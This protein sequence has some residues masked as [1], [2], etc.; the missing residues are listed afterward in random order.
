MLKLLFI[1]FS[2]RLRCNKDHDH[3]LLCFEVEN[4]T[5]R[6]KNRILY[7]KRSANGYLRMTLKHKLRK[8]GCFWTTKTSVNDLRDTP[9]VWYMLFNK[10][11]LNHEH[12]ICVSET[13][14]NR[15][16]ELVVVVNVDDL[17]CCGH[18]EREINKFEDYM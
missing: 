14:L 13:C 4:E 2:S 3:P 16:E 10:K 11:L 1:F 6:C 7:G 15:E 9:L 8:P 17:S 12:K 5:T 18:H